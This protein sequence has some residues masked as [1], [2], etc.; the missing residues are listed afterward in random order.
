MTLTPAGQDNFLTVSSLISFVHYDRLTTKYDLRPLVN[1]K[2]R[3]FHK[4]TRS[5]TKKK[6]EQNK[7][8][9][10]QIS[11][12]NTN[13]RNGCTTN[14]FQRYYIDIE[15]KG[16]LDVQ[17]LYGNQSVLTEEIIITCYFYICCDQVP[18]VM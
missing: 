9:T 4:A 6:T 2:G 13:G 3:L 11:F 18:S 10:S 8:K 7:T 17:S 16:Y 1:I 15:R 12:I 14:S 5:P